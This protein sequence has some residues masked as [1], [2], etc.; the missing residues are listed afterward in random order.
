MSAPP[1]YFRGP[2]IRLCV[3]RQHRR[4]G[5]KADDDC[6]PRP[7]SAARNLHDPG[8][9]PTSALPSAESQAAATP[10][11]QYRCQIAPSACTW[12]SP[13]SL[14]AC[15]LQP[16]ACARSP[17][18]HLTSPPL[19]SRQASQGN[20]H[21]VPQGASQ[22]HPP[23]PTAPKVTR[24][25]DLHTT[26][27]QLLGPIAIGFVLRSKAATTPRSSLLALLPTWSSTSTHPIP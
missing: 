15:S 9:Q 17:A 26:R 19:P 1:V 20:P 4:C 21:L 14:H 11:S 5:G 18:A 6:L 16:A 24:T 10:G 22:S 8:T 12:A 27:V 13:P 2:L 25:P 3:L 7:R 23:L